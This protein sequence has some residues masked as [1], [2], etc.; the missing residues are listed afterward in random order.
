MR[1]EAALEW[2]S[3]WA[4]P[5]ALATF[6]AVVLIIVSL[7]VS[8]VS[9]DGDAEVLRSVDANSGSALLSGLMRAV[10]FALLAFPLAY[11]FRAARARSDQVRTQLI[12]LVVAAPLFLGL[13]SGFAAV[14]QREAADEFVA[15]EAKVTLTAKEANEDCVEEREDEGNDFLV[16]EY[17]PAKGETPLKAC[18]TTKREDDAAS[19][20]QTEATFTP[21][22]TGLGI[23]GGLGFVVALFYSCLWA[24]R[25]G[26]L[27]RFW[28]SLGMALGVA[29]LFG[30]MPFVL[31]WFLYFGVLLLDRLPGGRPPAW[32]AGE[33]IP[34]PTPGEK[35]AAE[36]E[37][38]DGWEEAETDGEDEGESGPK[39]KRKQRE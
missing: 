10:A 36:L 27:S 31:L 15:G 6:A 33:A 18:E 7:F 12:G 11:L 37:P 8:N 16:D 32:A 24:M 28:G 9:G 14:A 2:E 25:T 30:L 39:R 13:S 21:F 34:W 5:V 29:A 20:A 23:A 4:V 22:A 3:R 35:A 17:A 38:E 1:R 19:N 26:L